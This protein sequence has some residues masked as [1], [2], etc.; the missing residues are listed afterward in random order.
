MERA[1]VGSTQEDTIDT[2][3][4]SFGHNRILSRLETKPPA[5]LES[6]VEAWKEHADPFER[7][8]AVILGI[9][10][11]QSATSIADEAAVSVDTARRYLDS[12]VE[13]TVVR[14]HKVG[15]QTKYEPD[16]LYTR[17]QTV[18]DLLDSHDRGSLINLRDELQ[19]HIETWRGEY[20]ADS[21]DALRE[22]AAADGVS[23]Q[24]ASELTQ[25]ASDWELAR[26]RL[27]LVQDAIKNYDTWTSE[28]SSLTV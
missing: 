5:M 14:E 23:A 19:A 1:G 10:E 9:S 28:L 25:A 24:Q 3:D 27:S 12:L 7:I 17:L 20:D 22:R 21:P 4:N 2:L 13:L 16:P 8:Q 26:Y 11:P 18:R 6:G 15:N